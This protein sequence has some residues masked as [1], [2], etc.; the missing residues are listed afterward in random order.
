MK[1]HRYQALVIGATLSAIAV[2]SARAESPA[3]AGS[4]GNIVRGSKIVGAKLFNT[5][6]EQMGTI[7]D[8]LVN[9][10]TGKVS[11]AV[12]GAG[13]FL[14]LGDKKTI[15]PRSIVQQD[16]QNPEAFVTTTEKQR[17]QQAPNFQGEDQWAMVTQPDYLKKIQAHFGVSQ[18]QTD[19]QAQQQQQAAQQAQAEAQKRADE[20]AQAAQK[21]VQDAQKALD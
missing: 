5:K 1:T 17:L 13:G 7:D 12:L 9:P 3:T 21:K 10:K 8:V 15:V 4:S 14:G 16:Q 2:L 20:Q 11:Y 19:T 18:Q 6:G